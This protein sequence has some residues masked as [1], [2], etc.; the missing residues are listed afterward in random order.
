MRETD[1]GMERRWSRPESTKSGTTMMTRRGANCWRAGIDDR[2]DKSNEKGVVVVVV[3][4]S[5][6]NVLIIPRRRYRSRSQP[7]RLKLI[8]LSAYAISSFPTKDTTTH[9]L[10]AIRKVR[11]Q[12]PPPPQPSLVSRSSPLPPSGYVLAAL[13]SRGLRNATLHISPHQTGVETT[14]HRRPRPRSPAEID[15]TTPAVA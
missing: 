4:Y 2:R 1:G 7:R 11:S 15:G 6:P 13:P 5:T 12:S 8:Q 9:N 14:H 10:Y 3:I